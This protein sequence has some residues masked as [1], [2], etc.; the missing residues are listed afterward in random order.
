M[1]PGLR[2]A[3]D[4]EARCLG[5]APC[6]SAWPPLEHGSPRQVY[7]SLRKEP[8]GRPHVRGHELQMLPQG[9]GLPSSEPVDGKKIIYA[10]GGPQDAEDARACGRR[11]REESTHV[12]RG[13][14][15]C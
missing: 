11:R 7:E 1:V 8:L 6:P 9:F 4:S 10:V 14:V 3:A 15:V 12:G 2:P 5:C 13:V